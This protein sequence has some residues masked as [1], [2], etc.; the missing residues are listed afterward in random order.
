MFGYV[1]SDDDTGDEEP[2]EHRLLE[3]DTT[4]PVARRVRCSCGWET[5]EGSG[6]TALGAWHNHLASHGAA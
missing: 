5:S 4:V 1:A 3:Y 2:C 6:K